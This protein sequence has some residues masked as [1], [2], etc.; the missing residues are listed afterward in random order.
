MVKFENEWDLLGVSGFEE[1]LRHLRRLSRACL[2]TND[3][4]IVIVYS[5]HDRLFFCD[6]W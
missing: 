3:N 6:D 5:F 2:T 1:K 4:D